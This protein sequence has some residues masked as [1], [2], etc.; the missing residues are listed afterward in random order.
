MDAARQP[1]KKDD[2]FLNKILGAALATGLGLFGL[3]TLS[4][5]LFSDASASAHGAAPAEGHG[6][7]EVKTL[8]Q[9]MC[10]QFHYCIDVADIANTDTDAAEAVFD[11]GAAL[12]AADLAKGERI[13]NGQCKTCHT[14]DSGG[15]N[16]TGPNLHGVVGAVKAK[17]AGFKYSAALSGLGTAWTYENLNEWI[18]N[19]GAYVKGTS[20]SFAGIRKDPDRAAV[21][22]YLA[23]NTTG[24]PPFPAPLAAE[25]PAPAEGLAA[26]A[27]GDVV[28]DDGAPTPPVEPAPA[29]PAPAEPVPQ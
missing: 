24:A 2:L 29:E 25:A 27:E 23:S 12:V 1:K 3:N 5:M 11:L 17:H 18:K 9:Q 10:S 14:I 22:A 20:M 15:A 7:G 8:S 6:E 16:G 4:T 28:P 21:I 13:F 19:P 26:P